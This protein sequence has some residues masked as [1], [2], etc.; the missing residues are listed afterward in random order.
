MNKIAVLL[1]QE[2]KLFHTG[3]LALLWRCSNKNTLH[4]TIKRFVD[5]G[6]LHPIHKGFYSVLPLDRIDPVALG[7][8]SLH[9][10]CYV[11][12]ETIL[13][14]EG[15]ISQITNR[16]TL[17]SDVSRSFSINGHASLCRRLKPL[18]L[19]NSA[20]I[21]QENN[22]ILI[23]TVERA[24]ADMRYFNPHASFDAHTRIDWNAVKQVQKEVG[25]L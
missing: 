19:F 24:I 23:A 21:V 14:K 16:I 13:A 11:S 8:G 6:I 22:G 18:H 9:R 15:I 7:I 17:I 20:G 4:T 12:T 3:D 1:G 10:Y 2:Q 25:Y 5:R